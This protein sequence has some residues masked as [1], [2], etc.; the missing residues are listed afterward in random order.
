MITGGSTF[1]GDL[2]IMTTLIFMGLLF[3]AISAVLG[4]VSKFRQLSNC[5]AKATEQLP[6]PVRLAKER[7][8]RRKK[9]KV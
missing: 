1:S 6:A 4:I 7:I 5:Q 3:G 9:E 8:E 2:L